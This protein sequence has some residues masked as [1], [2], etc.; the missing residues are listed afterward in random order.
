MGLAH[1]APV[2]KKKL[3]KRINIS[4]QLFFKA[5]SHKP[6]Y[7]N[8]SMKYVMGKL[9]SPKGRDLPRPFI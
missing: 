2:K 4:L 5:V 1:K 7:S 9:R 8:R 6:S 3:S